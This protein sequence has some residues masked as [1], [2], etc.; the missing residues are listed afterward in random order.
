MS[1]L[2]EMMHDLRDRH[3]KHV[4]AI[5][6]ANQD[7]S[8]R[9]ATLGVTTVY[10]EED[11]VLRTSIGPLTEAATESLNN[12]VLLRY[13]PESLK[14]VG[15]EVIGFKRLLGGDSSVSP[16]FLGRLRDLVV[17]LDAH[18]RA[19]EQVSEALVRDLRELV[20]A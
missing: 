16:P 5:L 8:E 11:D 18:R 7:L 10:D 15:I 12:T 9:G 20:P 13:D 14:L 3:I 2:E 19:S 17:A 1:S 6:E 4:L